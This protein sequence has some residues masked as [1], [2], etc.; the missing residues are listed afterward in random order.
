VGFFKLADVVHISV[1][2]GLWCYAAASVF[3]LLAWRRFELQSRQ[4]RAFSIAASAAAGTTP[5][6]PART[7]TGQAAALAIAAVIMMIPAYAL[8][9][10]HLGMLGEPASDT[11]ILAGVFRLW[12]QDLGG[13][14]AIVFTAS[15]LVPLLKLGGLAWLLASARRQPGERSRRL[16][17]LHGAIDFIGRWSMLDV[18]LV[19]FLAGAVRFGKLALVQ[20][21]IGI[22]AFGAVVVLTM[23]ATHRFD[24]RIFWED[25]RPAETTP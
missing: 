2:P 4:E 7:S 11:T 5:S 23:L 10:M 6:V 25:A 18:F 3:S 17:R 24:P 8:P 15:F 22:T 14:A 9:V 1:G 16:A 20:P 13:L 12:E 19:A 21:R